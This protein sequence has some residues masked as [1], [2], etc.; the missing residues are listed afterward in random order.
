LND[1][2][3]FA[4]NAPASAAR[5]TGNAASQTWSKYDKAKEFVEQNRFL[6]LKSKNKRRGTLSQGKIKLNRV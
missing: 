4:I 6:R 2:K 3:L 1:K 5:I